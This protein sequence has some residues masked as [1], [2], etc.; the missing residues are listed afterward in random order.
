[1]RIAYHALALQTMMRNP[2][3]TALERQDH[4]TRTLTLLADAA[5]RLA[6]GYGDTA[7]GTLARNYAATAA[8]AARQH[9]EAGLDAHARLVRWTPSRTSPSSWIAR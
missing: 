9:L 7:T 1:M 6:H 3:L 2:D 4:A 8:T 5:R